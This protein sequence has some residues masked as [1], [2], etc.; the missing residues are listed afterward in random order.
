M[1]NGLSNISAKSFQIGNYDEGLFDNEDKVTLTKKGEFNSK[2]EAINF[3]KNS[4]GS[5]LIVE[6]QNQENRLTYDVYKITIHDPGKKIH[7]LQ[8]AKNLTL[9]DKPLEVIEKNTKTSNSIKAVIVAENGEVSNPIFNS[10][11]NKTF[12]DTMREKLNLKEN[13]VWFWLVDNIM[14]ASAPPDNLP[15]IDMNEVQNMKKYLKKGDIIMNGLDGSFIHGILYVGEDKELQ[16]QL[17]KKWGLKK[18][19]L[20]GEGLIIHS[21]VTDGEKTVDI[22]GKKVTLKPSGVGVNIDTIERYILRHPRDVMIAV[23]VDS[24][25]NKQR[26]EVINV[27]KKFIGVNYDRAFNT[28]DDSEMYCTEFVMKAWQNTS[29]PPKFYTQKHNLVSYPQFILDKLPSKLSKAMQDGG[30]LANEMIMTDGLATSPSVKVVW[31]SQNADKSE[32]IKKHQR[33]SDGVNGKLGSEYRNMLMEHLPNQAVRSKFLVE[34]IKKLSQRTR[35]EL[36]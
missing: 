3:S 32:F 12:Y 36:K 14:G 28:K 30:L 20:N 33:W 22:N 1:N 13:K 35:N 7:K 8:D 15:E 34:E 27:A 23:S 19:E 17:E 5:E 2:G 16:S 10:Q 11:F 31:A 4:K 25:D 9:F 18:G 24:A 6:R 21:L 29:N 26:N